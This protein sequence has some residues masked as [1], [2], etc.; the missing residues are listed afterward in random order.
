M[1]LKRVKITDEE[2]RRRKAEIQRRHYYR[3]KERVLEQIR[4]YQATP[5]GKQ[6]AFKAHARRRKTD[7]YKTYHRRYCRNRYRNDFNYRIALNLR[8]RLNQAVKKNQRAGSAVRDLG[9]SI[10]DFKSYIESLWQSGMTW[11]T[12]GNASG[13]W[14]FDHTKPLIKFDLT[15][16]EQFQVACH[17][18]N[19]TPMWA[20]ENYSKGDKYGIEEKL[21]R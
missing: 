11:N 12:Y 16:V 7:E 8:S 18:T 21:Q 5:K 2:R 14:N 4:R 13:C 9:C 19:I 15:D 6:A 17:Y 3:N 10:P 1:A 20:S